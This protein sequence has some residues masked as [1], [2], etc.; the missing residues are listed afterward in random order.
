VRGAV[1]AAVALL[2]AAPALAQG[3][4]DSVPCCRAIGT[5]DRAEARYAGPKLRDWMAA[6]LGGAKALTSREP[7]PAIAQFCRD[8][9]DARFVPMVVTGHETVESWTCRGKRPEGEV[10]R[11]GRCPG[12]REGDLAAGRALSEVIE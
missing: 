10:G 11:T 7:T 3:F 2:G 4:T 5:I 6:K 12:L 9:P 8:H 1:L